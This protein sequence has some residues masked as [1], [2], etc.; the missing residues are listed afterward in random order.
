[1][2]HWY[3]P[4]GRAPAMVPYADPSRGERPA[5]L[6]DARKHGWAPGVIDVIRMLNA[7]RLNRWRVREAIKLTQ[8]TLR[9]KSSWVFLEPDALV[10]QIESREDTSKRD[11]GTEIHADIERRVRGESYGNRDIVNAVLGA[12]HDQFP[13]ASWDAEVTCWGR[14][15]VLN[16]SYGGTIDLFSPG[17]VVDVKTKESL[18]GGKL[19]WDEHIMQLAAYAHAIRAERAANLFVDYTGDVEIIE[20]DSDALQRGRRQFELA[21]ELFYLSKGL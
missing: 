16:S 13:N 10:I 5:T 19:Q 21:R 18:S 1:M 8:K 14:F 2:S 11:L 15:G 12:L 9:D 20:V 6:R 3:T 4:D 7:E 17:I